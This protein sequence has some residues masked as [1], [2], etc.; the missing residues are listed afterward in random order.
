MEKSVLGFYTTK[1]VEAKLG[2]YIFPW[3]MKDRAAMGLACVC[4]C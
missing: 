1:F 3:S 2:M 4:V